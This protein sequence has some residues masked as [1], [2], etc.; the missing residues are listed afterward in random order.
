MVSQDSLSPGV[1]RAE[2]VAALSLATDL[3]L[4]APTDFAM[5]TCVL[6]MRL[7]EALKLPHEE[8]REVYWYGLSRHVGCNA[9]SHS[10]A[11][12]FSDEIAF[13]RE[14]AVTDVGKPTELLPFACQNDPAGQGRGTPARARCARRTPHTGLSASRKFSSRGDRRPLRGGSSASPERLGFGSGRHHRARPEPGALGRAWA[15]CRRQ[16]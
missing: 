14:I 15:A 3:A 12:F 7:G 4:G 2:V 16:G 8:L 6:A 11:A 1:R 13:N 9:E 10:V 5:R